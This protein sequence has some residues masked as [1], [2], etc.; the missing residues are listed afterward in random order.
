MIAGVAASLP[1]RGAAL[2]VDLR[3]EADLAG[4]S[5]LLCVAVALCAVAITLDMGRESGIIR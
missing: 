3:M 5:L 1:D 4:M 2:T